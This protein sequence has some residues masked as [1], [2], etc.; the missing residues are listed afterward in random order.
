MRGRERERQGKGRREGGREREKESEREQENAA[1]ESHRAGPTVRAQRMSNDSDYR[2]Q[3]GHHAAASMPPH[4][5]P[6]KDL[7]IKGS[8]PIREVRGHSPQH[9]KAHIFHWP[10][11]LA[12]VQCSC[13][14]ASGPW[15]P[16][17]KH[18]LRSSVPQFTHL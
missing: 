17:P 6:A 5:M 10:Q 18:M 14:S 4:S 11:L 1:W 13:P 3:I 16:F 2:T 15:E 7:G 9:K 8:L 12:S